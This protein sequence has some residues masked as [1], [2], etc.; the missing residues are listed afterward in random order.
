MWISLHEVN[1]NVNELFVSEL[2]DVIQCN[3][4]NP[5]TIYDLNVEIH[6]GNNSTNSEQIWAII[7]YI[8]NWP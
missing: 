6:A 4:N 5:E 7:T 3:P 2:K 8:H 1:I